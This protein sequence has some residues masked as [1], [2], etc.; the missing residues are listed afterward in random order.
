MFSY[1]SEL[2]INTRRCVEV[3]VTHIWCNK[4]LIMIKKSAVWVK[5]QCWYRSLKF[6]SCMV[7]LLVAVTGDRAA[8]EGL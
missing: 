7:V 2:L 5:L 8:V 3:A 4:G 6:E 1:L